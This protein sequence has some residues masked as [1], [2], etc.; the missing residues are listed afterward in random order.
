MLNDAVIFCESCGK[1]RIGRIAYSS[2]Q[3]KHDA[4]G[5]DNVIG[6][7]LSLTLAGAQD[8]P[9][10]ASSGSKGATSATIPLTE[11][12]QNEMVNALSKKAAEKQP[13]S[14]RVCQ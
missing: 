2:A 10:L 3:G 1:G 5:G 4:K 12:A 7:L 8:V 9:R 14:T 13:A 11:P 6:N